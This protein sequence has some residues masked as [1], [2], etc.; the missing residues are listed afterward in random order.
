MVFVL[1]TDS[2]AR[3]VHVSTKSR[4]TQ[5]EVQGAARRRGEE[6]RRRG[7]EEAGERRKVVEGGEGGVG[8]LIKPSKLTA[9]LENQ[10]NRPSTIT[11]TTATAST[12]TTTNFSQHHG[13]V[14]SFKDAWEIYMTNSV[15]S[16]SL[17]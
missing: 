7:G 9:S 12:T 5:E 2:P 13:E 17:F 4:V 3:V 1:D 6:V 8:P 15:C 10:E 11:S 14:S 16:S